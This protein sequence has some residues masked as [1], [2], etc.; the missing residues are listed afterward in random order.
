MS[1]TSNNSNMAS[2]LAS[3]KA[4]REVLDRFGLS[5]KHS[6]GQNFLVNDGVVQKILALAQVEKD[7]YLLEV[8]PGI[9]TLSRGLL[10]QGC[11]LTA[12]ERD[13][14]MQRVLTSTLKDFPDTFYLIEGDALRLQV[15]DIP[16]R[17]HGLPSKFVAN[18]PYAVAATLILNY[19]QNFAFLSSATV[20]VQKEVAD[21][22]AARPGTKDY[23]AYTVKLS[24]YAELVSR[25]QV[26]PGNFF[27]PPHVESTVL[28]LDRC[29]PKREDGK[30]LQAEELDAISVMVDAAFATRRKTILNSCKA[31]FAG[32]QSHGMKVSQDLPELLQAAGIDPRRRGETLSREEFIRLGQEYF[33]RF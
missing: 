2:E 29:S 18:L 1:S 26:G 24:L 17:N 22:I 9:G 23:G 19:F 16:E 7:D 28:R 14:D 6:L 15:S 4:T 21:R 33:L 31:Y 30:P 12:V 10:K 5:A 25:F 32:R 20:M 27:P 13:K 8:G 3:L 11:F